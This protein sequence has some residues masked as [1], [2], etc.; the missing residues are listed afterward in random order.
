VK[1]RVDTALGLGVFALV[2]AGLFGVLAWREVR[3]PQGEPLTPYDVVALTTPAAAR[4]S[5]APVGGRIDEQGRLVILKAPATRG[6][7]EPRAGTA[8]IT[9]ELP[10]SSRPVPNAVLAG[11]RGLFTLGPVPLGEGDRL[12]TF[13]VPVP[14]RGRLL[15]VDGCF[16]FGSVDGPAAVFPFG[17]MLGLV[18]GRLVVGP[19]GFAAAASARVGEVIAWPG[20]IMR[21]ISEEGMAKLKRVCRSSEVLAVVPASAS[22]AETRYE[23]DLAE[24]WAAKQDIA[25]SAALRPVRQCLKRVRLGRGYEPGTPCELLIPPTPPAP[26]PAPPLSPQPR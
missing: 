15:L 9:D 11:I 18:D 19:A 22:V 13:D 5:T 16:R 2:L 6:V 10:R 14:M 8:P 20:R 21:P 23:S 25:F 4:A 3:W 12:M 1:R 7:A 26:P 24:R 17:S